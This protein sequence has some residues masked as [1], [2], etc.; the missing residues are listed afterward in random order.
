MIEQHTHEQDALQCDGIVHATLLHAAAPR[1][2]SVIMQ[3][4]AKELEIKQPKS[5]ASH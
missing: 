4:G 5:I 3:Q 1:P 2:K